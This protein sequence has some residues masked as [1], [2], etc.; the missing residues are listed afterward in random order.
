MAA[1]SASICECHGITKLSTDNIRWEHTPQWQLTSKL[2]ISKHQQVQLLEA[3]S[4]LVAMNQ[5][6]PAHDSDSSSPAASG[7]SD[8]QEDLPSSTETTPP[9]HHD[10]T[11][12]RDSKRHSNSSSVYS[13]SY[14]SIFSSGSAPHENA[15]SHAR[16]W[17]TSSNRPTTANT[18][19]A[20]SYPD[21]DPADL[22]AAVGL[23]SCSYR[24]PKNG[25]TVLADV[26][27]VPP[28]PAKYLDGAHNKAPRTEIVD[29]DMDDESN[30][31]YDQH[32]R[33]DEAEYGVF[34]KM[35]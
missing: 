1:V 2:L 11:S 19:I 35:D 27:P 14:Q 32:T 7:S 25:P 22:A 8:P 6:G 24:T 13:R 28:L 23:L 15:F 12:Y 31:D 29:I 33:H 4:V 34:G 10:H 9:P 26:P 17:S 30:S 20:E 16:Q 3:A 21:E 5:D 18:S